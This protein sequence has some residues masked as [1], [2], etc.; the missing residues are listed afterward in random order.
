[1][2]ERPEKFQVRVGCH[3]YTTTTTQF[4]EP[5]RYISSRCIAGFACFRKRGAT[6]KKVRVCGVVQDRHEGEHI[7][8]PCRGRLGTVRT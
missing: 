8:V 2:D 4:R 1:M 3:R 5:R 6:S 7:G